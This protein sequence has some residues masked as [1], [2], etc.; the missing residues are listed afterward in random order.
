M[1]ETI[2]QVNDHDSPKLDYGNHALSVC[3][4]AGVNFQVQKSEAL[5]QITSMMQASEEFAQFMNDDETLPILV[6][7]I[8]CYGAD[9]LKEAVP[10][11]IEKKSQMQQDRRM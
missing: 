6:D 8:T 3:I 9:R 11:W 2:A 4:E 10:K 1:I 5:A 7:N